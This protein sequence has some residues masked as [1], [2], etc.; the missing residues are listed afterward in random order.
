MSG[1][2]GMTEPGEGEMIWAPGVEAKVRRRRRR[3]KRG[4]GE[5]EG[6]MVQRNTG[7]NGYL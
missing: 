1:M 4:R 3:E 2:K 7:T 6:G 5:V